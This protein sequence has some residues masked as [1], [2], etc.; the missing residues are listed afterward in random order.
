MSSL[1]HNFQGNPFK[2]YLPDLA[3]KL[4]V[5]ANANMISLP[6]HIGTGFVKNVL[7]EENFCIR[8][9]N[10]SFKKDFEFEFFVEQHT[11]EVYYNLVYLLDSKENGEHSNNDAPVN[12][13]NILLY[14]NDFNRK[15]IIKKNT[16]LRR[17]AIIFNTTW[18]N[19]NYAEASIKMDGLI[20]SLTTKNKSTVLS[21]NLDIQ[22]R[23]IA[24]QL[25]NELD[26]STFVQIHVKNCRFHFIE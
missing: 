13:A 23:F 14:S 4:G 2:D 24:T 17:I 1:I 5:E 10:I 16:V 25:A 15:G 20:H 26:R 11:S 12:S 3:K 9:F 8:Y 6:P 21:E 19:N 7:I 18:L 22:N